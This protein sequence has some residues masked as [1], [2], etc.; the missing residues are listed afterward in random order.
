MTPKTRPFLRSATAFLLALLMCFS[1]L[2]FPAAAAGPIY[3]ETIELTGEFNGQFTLNSSDLQLFS[4]EA[5]TPGTSWHGK[6]KVV[7][8]ASA[9]MEFA[10]ISIESNLS[11]TLLYNALDLK[12][13]ADQEEIYNGSYGATTIPISQKL[14]IPAGKS[15]TYDIIVTLPHTVGNE[16]MGKEM[17]STWVFEADYF[18]SKP[19]RDRVYQVKY[20]DEE[21]ND[22]LPTKFGR[23]PYNST[24]TEKAEK[25]DGYTPD[26]QEKS[27]VIRTTLDHNTIIF[28]Y[29]KKSE[30]PVVPAPDPVDPEPEDPKPVDPEPVD[31]TPADPEPE[32][33]KPVDP[34]PVDPTPADPEPVDPEPTVPDP[35]PE[36]PGDDIKTGADMTKSNTSNQ[37]WW[38]ILTLSL[39]AGLVTYGRV[40]AE[41]KRLKVSESKHMSN[42]EEDRSHG[43]D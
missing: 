9:R 27:L 5:V 37:L 41:K 28:V 21:G 16:M 8:K 11:D 33:P 1:L 40:K 22:L 14:N 3:E 18:G 25:I 30:D 13:Y 36:T 10:I 43:V 23:A 42:K 34:E 38:V 31:P 20:V 24:V 19:S 39:F 4:L 6:L 2:P 26:A 17:D 29:S 32:E 35:E 7:N 15:V 12:I